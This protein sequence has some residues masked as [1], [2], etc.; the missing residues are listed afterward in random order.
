MP[1]RANTCV[2]SG[3]AFLESPR[4]HGDR[5]WLSDM[6]THQV[7]SVR[8]D[9]GDPRTEAR[10]PGQPSGLGWLPDGRLLIVSMRDQRLLRREPDGTLVTHADLSGLVT[11][12]LNDM[13]VDRYGRAFVGHFGFDLMAGDPFAPAGLLR[14]DPD[15][16]VAHVAEDLWFPNGSVITADGLLLVNETLGNRITA[17]DLTADG[18][19][20]GRRTW[21]RFGELP[22]A[23]DIPAMLGQIV[24]GGDGAALDAEGAL[25]VADAV[26]GR[27][28]RIRSGEIVDEIAAETGVFAC[29]LGGADGRT[30][31]LCAAPDFDEHARSAAREGVILSARVDIPAAPPL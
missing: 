19:L 5:L 6:Y 10:V 16:T 22:T 24:V 20:A 2:L 31:F 7:L 28:V 23:T 8:A 27:A 9:G 15:G 11:G 26:N 14:V 29:A 18:R 13:V 4:W 21:A 12:H 17:F 30:L 1:N 25:W 3:F